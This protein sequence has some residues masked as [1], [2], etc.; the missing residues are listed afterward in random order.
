MRAGAAQIEI[1]DRRRGA[2]PREERT[3]DEQL[4]ERQ[5]AVE[6][7]A[8]GEAVV[9]LEVE[10]RDHLA[11]DDRRGEAGGEPLDR[12]RRG[13]AEAVA[14]GVPRRAAQMVRRVL[15]VR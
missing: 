4:I 11:R 7:V 5:L 9:A 1:L 8:A 13:R 10:R 15:H 14:L 2:G 12:P 6:D 3:A